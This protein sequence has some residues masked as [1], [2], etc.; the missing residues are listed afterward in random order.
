MIS[1][2][3]GRISNYS[4]KVYLYLI[5]VGRREDSLILERRSAAADDDFGTFRQ[6][7]TSVFVLEERSGAGKHG[8]IFLSGANSVLVFERRSGAAE[9]G[10]EI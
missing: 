9:D 2:A 10:L 7:R 4:L 1:E 6:R 5:P 8:E 3:R